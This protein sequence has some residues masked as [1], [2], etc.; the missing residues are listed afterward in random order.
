MFLLF[1]KCL[2]L[3]AALAGVFA[4]GGFVVGQI[5]WVLDDSCYD[6]NY[7][8]LKNYK[9][10]FYGWSVVI[11]AFVGVFLALF[12][13]LLCEPFEASSKIHDTVNA[14]YHQL[15]IEEARPMFEKQYEKEL[16]DFYSNL[17]APTR[18]AESEKKKGFKMYKEFEF[19]Y[20]VDKTKLNPENIA[21]YKP[22][23]STIPTADKEKYERLVSMLDKVTNIEFKKDNIIYTVTEQVIPANCSCGR[24]VANKSTTF[25][26]WH[27]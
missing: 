19:L 21:A 14:K 18:F 5:A 23:M 25:T 2:G 1:L 24:C 20:Y 9:Q 7:A 4:I 17:I 12:A 16:E 11:G 15:L 27:D 13:F 10:K 8:E 22:L 3:V 26:I 6:Y